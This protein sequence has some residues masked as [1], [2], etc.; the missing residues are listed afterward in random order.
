MCHDT[1]SH[2][3][4]PLAQY[5]RKITAI[6]NFECTVFTYVRISKNDIHRYKGSGPVTTGR[7]TT[8]VTTGP[9]ENGTV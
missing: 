9:V 4:V 6:I 5:R 2:M 8:G 7:I 3:K 1:Q